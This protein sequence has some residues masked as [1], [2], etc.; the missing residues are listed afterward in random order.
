MNDTSEAA[1]PKQALAEKP[2][3][4]FVPD[5]PAKRDDQSERINMIFHILDSSGQLIG[6]IFQDAEYSVLKRG[7]ETFVG[8]LSNLKTMVLNQYPAA[9]FVAQEEDQSD[10][11]EGFQWLRYKHNADLGHDGWGDEGFRP[12]DGG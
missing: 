9:E 11:D 4:E 2:P 8:P 1:D 7:D 5:L 12:E 6:V 3:D 10:E